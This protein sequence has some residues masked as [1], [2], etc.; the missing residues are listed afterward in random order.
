MVAAVIDTLEGDIS[1]YIVLWVS[2]KQLQLIYLPPEV[3]NVHKHPNI[4]KTTKQACLK[5]CEL[6]LQEQLQAAVKL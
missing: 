4:N 5:P 3:P 2:P 6:E 1:S